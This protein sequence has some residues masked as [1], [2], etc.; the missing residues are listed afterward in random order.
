MN[1]KLGFVLS[2]GRTGTVFLTKT[3]TELFPDILTVHEPGMSRYQYLLGNF[4]K[5]WPRVTP[6][7]NSWYWSGRRSIHGDSADDKQGYI[8]I[9]PFLCSFV[10]VLTELDQPLRIVHI[11]RHPY[12]WIPSMLRFKAKGWRRNIIN[13]LPYNHPP[14]AMQGQNQVERLA[15]RWKAY[16]Q[17]IASLQHSAASYT[18]VRFEDLFSGDSNVATTAFRKILTTIEL[19]DIDPNRVDLSTKVN[20]SPGA[21]A[22]VSLDTLIEP[23]QLERVRTIVAPVA[24]QLGY[25]L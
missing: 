12:S 22:T 18:L 5:Q 3:L 15:W 14:V 8:E 17:A 1:H 11:V 20:A 10:G 25:D 23:Q 21:R 2:T 6:L 24:E 4:C 16:N 9:N 13:H 7:L 19:N